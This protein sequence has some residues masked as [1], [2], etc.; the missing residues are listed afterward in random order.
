MAITQRGTGWDFG[1]RKDKGEG[2]RMK[3]TGENE[4][5]GPA[6]EK[7]GKEKRLAIAVSKLFDKPFTHCCIQAVIFAA[8]PINTHL[9]SHSLVYSAM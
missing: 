7:Q 2:E 6:E 8:Q 1:D 5:M 3:E 4:E 9:F